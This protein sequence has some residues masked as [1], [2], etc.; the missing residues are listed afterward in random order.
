MVSFSAAT[1]YPNKRHDYHPILQMTKLRPRVGR[2]FVQVAQLGGG[3]IEIQT[4][5]VWL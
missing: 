2:G 4:R 1:T 3:R 5:S